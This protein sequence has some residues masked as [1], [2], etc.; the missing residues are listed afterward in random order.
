MQNWDAGKHRNAG[1]MKSSEFRHITDELLSAYLD[2]A[3]SEQERA[4]VEAV[5]IAEPDI[6][7]RLD[8]L[9]QTV[10]LLRNLPELALPRSFALQE[11]Q[12]GDALVTSRP[13]ARP[14]PD[15]AAEPVA[16]GFW[17]GLVE[18]WRALWQAGNPV[19]R[20][21]AAASLVLLLLLVGSSSF[22]ATQPQMETAQVAYAP[23]P[24]A[25][26]SAADSA[27]EAQPAQEGAMTLAAP[28]ESETGTAEM[29]AEPSAAEGVSA[30]E[31]ASGDADPSMTTMAAPMAAAEGS[32]TVQGFAPSEESV[33]SG[34]A[35]MAQSAAIPDARDETTG[36]EPLLTPIA[37]LPGPL[38]SAPYAPGMGGD[39]GGAGGAGGGPGAAESVPAYPGGG[40]ALLPPAAYDTAPDFVPAEPA[41]PLAA[42]E[43]TPQPSVTEAEE[44]PEVAMLPPETPTATPVTEDA[45]AKEPD[46][47][48]MAR[49]V[50]TNSAA[51][52]PTATAARDI[53][54]TG[55][56]LLRMAQIGLGLITLMLVS[57]WWRSR[58]ESDE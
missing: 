45:A 52:T 30:G 23:A 9:R 26:E 21:A 55:S 49:G 58:S 31:P 33:E 54:V 34:E 11:A 5:V 40:D 25:R 6:A 19:L 39:R 35:A 16:P 56:G 37:P 17:A 10:H 27:A 57:L 29:P 46:D 15:R 1:I 22:L 42:Q 24:T 43:S 47:E 2:G 51:T 50:V 20:N 18:S 48:T 14:A 7:W 32:P 13:A 38:A 3:V 41:G 44:A 53:L 36:A 8:T 4:L 28:A 12:L